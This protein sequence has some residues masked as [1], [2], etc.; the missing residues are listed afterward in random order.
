MARIRKAVAELSAVAVCGA[1]Y[2]GVGVPACVASG[3]AVRVTK[4]KAAP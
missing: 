4:R 3:Q 1:A 2:D